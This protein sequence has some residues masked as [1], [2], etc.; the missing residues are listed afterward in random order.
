MEE[1]NFVLSRGENAILGKGREGGSPRRGI[2]Q[3]G[4]GHKWDGGT[5]RSRDRIN[6]RGERGEERKNQERCGGTIYQGQK[7][8][9]SSRN[10]ADHLLGGGGWHRVRGGATDKGGSQKGVIWTLQASSQKTRWGIKLKE[11]GGGARSGKNLCVT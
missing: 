1:R 11:E 10:G 4:G 9:T 3:G 2:T 6:S 7:G 5:R 8:L